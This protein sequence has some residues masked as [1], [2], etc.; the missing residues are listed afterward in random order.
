M[1]AAD[2]VVKHRERA[3][4]AHHHGEPV[5]GGVAQGGEQEVA[6]VDELGDQPDVRAR[7]RKG[8]VGPYR[9]WTR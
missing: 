5:G 6:G 3:A 8:E 2:F 1:S 9:V 4:H 7:R